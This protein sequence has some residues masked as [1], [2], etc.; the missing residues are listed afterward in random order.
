MK[1]ILV[2]FEMN[3]ARGR[4]RIALKIDY[5]NFSRLLAVGE[6]LGLY[7]FSDVSFTLHADS[8]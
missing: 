7:T 4:C 6:S 1:E 3:K 5:P 8:S 2:L